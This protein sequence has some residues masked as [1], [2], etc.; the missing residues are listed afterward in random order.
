LPVALC[1]A[2]IPHFSEGTLCEPT[3]PL[4]LA[5]FALSK[6]SE[7]KWS[8]AEPRALVLA[9]LQAAP[10]AA[11]MIDPE[12]KQHP[13]RAL[14]A[15]QQSA[16]LKQYYLVEQKR[17]WLRER[18]LWLGFYGSS[19]LH[20]LPKAAIIRIAHMITEPDLA[21]VL[22]SAA[23]AAA[24]DVDISGEA[25][26]QQ[27]YSKFLMHDVLAQTLNASNDS[28]RRRHDSEDS[29][30][31]TNG[32]SRPGQAVEP[33]AMPIRL[34]RMLLALQPD[35][36][37]SKMT[38]LR[39]PPFFGFGFEEHNELVQSARD[40]Q[41]TTG[42]RNEPNPVHAVV[43]LFC[44]GTAKEEESVGLLH[45]ARRLLELAPLTAI[46]PDS[47]GI[48]PISCLLRFCVLPSSIILPIT[49][50]L[51][52]TSPALWQLVIH[53]IFE[54]RRLKRE[55]SDVVLEALSRMRPD[56]RPVR[57]AMMNVKCSTTVIMKVMESFPVEEWKF[58]DKILEVAPRPP[59]AR[60]GGQPSKSQQLRP[61]LHLALIRDDTECL[62][63]ALIDLCPADVALEMQVSSIPLSVPVVRLGHHHSSCPPA[64]SY[65]YQ[66]REILQV[67]PLEY[68]TR[69]RRSVCVLNALHDAL[70]VNKKQSVMAT[71]PAM[72]GPAAGPPSPPQSSAPPPAA[73]PPVASP[74]ID[75][76]ALE[77]MHAQVVDG[78]HTIEMQS[79]QIAKVLTTPPPTKWSVGFAVG[80]Q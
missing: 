77:S 74:M 46:E 53:L 16:S 38:N 70:M 48:V 56:A 26:V 43:Y 10:S 52:S 75:T 17:D 50:M 19:P 71:T 1:I 60:L 15:H 4:H 27:R 66:H 44:N 24:S 79:T 68:A 33:P 13:L 9:L 45:F 35:A 34:L 76:S 54:M 32:N 22:L 49:A 59:H 62:V 80:A 40:L 64:S 29:R 12:S 20:M 41:W 2:L 73:P 55:A 51:G 31:S 36:A 78:Q 61:L 23:P 8:G 30:L 65:H 14:L 69:A 63:P 6:G 72:A 18:E 5:C 47:H 25:R 21:V 7:L 11:G 37:N 3:T 28:S 42:V 57:M 39:P 67:M 58:E